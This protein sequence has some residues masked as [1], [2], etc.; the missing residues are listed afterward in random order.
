MDESGALEGVAFAL[1]AEVA[2]GEATELVVD[3]GSEGVEG[4]AVAVAPLE[5]KAG[6]VCRVGQDLIVGAGGKPQQG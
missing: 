6:D 5:E 3:E 1:A 4:L 2:G